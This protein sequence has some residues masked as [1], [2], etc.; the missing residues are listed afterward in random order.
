MN[1]GIIVSIQ[2]YSVAT[3]YE[4]A[5]EAISGGC[6]GLRLDKR[7]AIPMDRAVPI[8]GLKKEKGTDCKI[9]P[10]ITHTLEAVRE[11]AQW[12][13][14]VA[15][16]SRRC[17]PNLPEIARFCRENRIKVVADVET[18]E[19]F[20]DLKAR[21]L[22]YD[23]V[24]T[25]LS[26]L[27]RPAG[28]KFEPDLDLVRRIAREERNLIAEG[29]FSSRKD[30]REAYVLGARCVCIGAAIANVYKLTKKYTSVPTGV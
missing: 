18:F 26:V 7:I 30:V 11:V 24:A 15:V 29:E 23:F 12:A 5:L 19:D 17:N 27:D 4:L 22:P 9:R 28:C 2:G 10:Y 1:R 21:G 8:V 13:D 3:T 20:A 6:I 14:L 25:T 16:D